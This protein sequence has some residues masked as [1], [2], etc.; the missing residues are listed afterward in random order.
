MRAA[1][2][3][4]DEAGA[5]AVL[6]AILVA[7]LV[8]G[9]ILF[10]SYVQRPLLAA[11]SGG[12]DLSGLAGQ[13]LGL[14]L[15][16]DFVVGGQTLDLDAW[17]RKLAAGDAATTAAVDDYLQ[18]IL[19]EGTEHALYLSNGVGTLRLAP[20]QDPGEPRNARVASAPYAPPWYAFRSNSTVAVNTSQLPPGTPIDAVANPVH[21]LFADPTDLTLACIKAPDGSKT[22]PEGA[23]IDAWRADTMRVPTGAP[24]GV[25]AGYV[26]AACTPAPSTQ[27]AR[28][29]L[30][31]ATVAAYADQDPDF[32]MYDL[33][34]AVWFGT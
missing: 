32:A 17:M 9:A 14:L 15:R 8:L 27:Y 16:H 25:W 10:V 2:R 22:G 23:W 1:P 5:L 26:D 3:V 11:E 6:E 30:R 33:R 7:V 29:S 20:A 19:P 34:L 28:V 24:Y 12:V 31:G 21:A 18:R 4:D 13:T